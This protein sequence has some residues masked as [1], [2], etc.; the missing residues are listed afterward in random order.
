M[1]RVRGGQKLL[2]SFAD[3]ELIKKLMTLDG[4][5][6]QCIS[7]G[8]S[9]VGLAFTPGGGVVGLDLDHC[10]A[11]NRA[12]V[13]TPEQK[14][15]LKLVSKHAFVEYSQSGT[16]LHAIALG[17]AATNK[18]NG[19]IELFGNKNFLALTG[20]GGRG[21][22]STLPQDNLA[23]VDL[24]INELKAARTTQGSANVL[25]LK[26][27]TIR[28]SGFDLS[29]N[30]DVVNRQSAPPDPERA[31]SALA[32]I[33]SPDDRDDWVKLVLASCA[34]G[35]D[36]PTMIA[37]S[38]PDSEDKI[39]E[40]YSSY[41]PKRPGGIRPG[42]LYKIATDAGWVAPKRQ[43]AS[44]DAATE[45]VA[46]Q[47]EQPTDIWLAK[48]FALKFSARFRFDHALKVWRVWRGGSWALCRK[49]EQVE[50][51]K[52]LANWLMGEASKEFRNDPESK[53]SKKLMACAMRAQ[54]S[55][56]IEAALKLAQSDPLIAVGSED[57]DK[58]PDL[59]NVVNGII[60]L[61]SGELRPHDAALMVYRQ[62]PVEYNP[63]ATCPR[64]E[65][66]MLQLS[67]DD[68][69]WVDYLQRVCGYALSG[70]VTE[71]KLFFLLGIGANGKSVFGN[72]QLHVMGSYGG[73]APAAFLM[74]R[75]GGD[76]N[77]PT[78]DILN[79]SGRRMV[80]A[81]EV[82]AGST[83]SGQTVKTT[84]STELITARALHGAPC[85]FKPTHKLF[86]RG[87]HRPIINDNDE[88]IWRRI[89]LIP[90]NLNLTTE[91]RDQGL[92]ARL[93]KEAP[94]ILAWMVRGFQRWKLE[95][96]RPARRVRDASLAYRRES[97][98][99]MQWMDDCCDSG[100]DAAGMFTAPQ[101]QAYD[102]YR[103]WCHDQGLRQFSKKSFTRGL[104][105]QGIKEGRQGSGQRLTTYVGFRLNGS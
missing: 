99:L 21:I 36:I 63:A 17:D 83:M 10:I 26:A 20:A 49:G 75:R 95:G 90:F 47:S 42:T 76:A 9:G 16:G 14:A 38:W 1:P 84:T 101:Q 30:E 70:H 52:H 15:A 86:I 13:L 53:R 41:D 81:N 4:A 68:P 82:E 34:A 5:I 46:V 31:K 40:L 11:E 105:E 58:D 2:G 91:Q 44:E 8:H 87:N 32:A 62:S 25:S 98:L 79:L 88:G 59:F 33:S 100:H 29:V 12:A 39:R 102:N 54:S 43:Q 35:V 96:L 56:G 28:A 77:G 93:M 22:A 6:E 48:Q 24:I 72:I 103:M 85:T 50:A 80:A 78:P 3:P 23:K 7:N 51:A 27:L 71:E 37:H 55:S 104:V 94:G 89:D 74:Y 69:D 60:H 66:F 45:T 67:C 97:D 57:F 18:V 64:F 92:E 73:V 19:S 65:A 61:P